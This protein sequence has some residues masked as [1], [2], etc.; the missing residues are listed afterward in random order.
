MPTLLLII[1]IAKAKTTTEKINKIYLSAYSRLPKGWET[2]A[3]LDIITDLGEAEAYP[4]ILTAL[5]ASNE[6]SFI[7]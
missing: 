3:C 6:F 1:A 2:K 5:L 4:V 7:Q